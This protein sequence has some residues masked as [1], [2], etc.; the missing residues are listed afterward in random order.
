MRGECTHTDTLEFPLH[1]YV[2]WHETK[3]TVNNIFLYFIHRAKGNKDV[4][5]DRDG[6]GPLYHK[7][8]ALYTSTDDSDDYQYCNCTLTKRHTYKQY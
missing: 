2:Q 5:C 8:S 7:A 4:L 6:L 1:V 3:H